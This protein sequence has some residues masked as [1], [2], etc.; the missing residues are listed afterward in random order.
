MEDSKKRK[1]THS[2]WLQVTATGFMTEITEL[3]N[4]VAIPHHFM[5]TT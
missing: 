1:Q 5:A 3:N 2:H 4:M